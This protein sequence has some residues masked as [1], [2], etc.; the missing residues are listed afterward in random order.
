MDYR[1]NRLF[2]LAC[3]VAVCIFIAV[4]SSLFF[5]WNIRTAAIGVIYGLAAY[6]L[7]I[8]ITTQCWSVVSDN[9]P[10]EKM[11]IP[12]F[13]VALF[14]PIIAVFAAVI[15]AIG[16]VVWFLLSVGINKES[17]PKGTI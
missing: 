12:A 9:D 14:L 6:G 4:L 16:Y 5:G 11:D 13:V 2:S 3:L 7:W 1:W 15:F 8:F 17:R 10:P